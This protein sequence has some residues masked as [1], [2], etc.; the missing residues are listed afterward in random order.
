M[1]NVIIG[2]Q[3]RKSSKKGKMGQA[4]YQ[5]VVDFEEHIGIWKSKNGELS[6]PTN[7]GTIHYSK[8]GAHI[9]PENPNYELWIDYGRD[10]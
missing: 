9:V 7:K 6:L 5:E 2:F 3:Q 1:D 4:G 8:D 10:T